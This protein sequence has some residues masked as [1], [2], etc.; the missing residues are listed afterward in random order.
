MAAKSVV[1]VACEPL[2]ARI[3]ELNRE[4]DGLMNAKELVRRAHAATTAAEPKPRRTR[5]PNKQKRGLPNAN[6]QQTTTG[7]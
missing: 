3:A 4:I 7:E 5:G 1:D 6:A 2:D